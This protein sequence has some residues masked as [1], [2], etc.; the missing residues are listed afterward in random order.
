MADGPVEDQFPQPIAA[1]E[2]AQAAPGQAAPAPQPA[3]NEAQNAKLDV[4]G[5][6]L[7]HNLGVCFHGTLLTSASLAQPRLLVPVTESF[8]LLDKQ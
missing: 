7:V 5:F 4:F 8:L 1:P 3:Q 2:E 6:W